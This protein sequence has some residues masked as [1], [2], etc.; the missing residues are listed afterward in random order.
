M[1]LKY[2]GVSDDRIVVEPGLER[3]LDAAVAG[4]EERLYALPTYTAM[5]ELRELLAGRGVASGS[6]A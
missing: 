6:F 1:R 4:A 3:A 5:L 2:A